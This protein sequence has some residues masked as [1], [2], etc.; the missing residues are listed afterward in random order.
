[1]AG[2]SLLVVRSDTLIKSLQLSG[3]PQ[4][5]RNQAYGMWSGVTRLQD[6]CEQS[7]L[8]NGAA[9][10][11]HV[12]GRLSSARRFAKH[13]D[14]RIAGQSGRLVAASAALREESGIATKNSENNADETLKKGFHQQ[15]FTATERPQHLHQADLAVQIR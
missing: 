15:R 12:K 14:A 5:E 8:L 10:P 7:L 13:R 11:K 1:M 3:A 4:T 9:R 6:C 2:Q